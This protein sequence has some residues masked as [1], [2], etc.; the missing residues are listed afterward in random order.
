MGRRM[1]RCRRRNEGWTGG[2]SERSQ[3]P[4]ERQAETDLGRER[5]RQTDRDKPT[6]RAE[7]QRENDGKGEKLL[8]AAHE[9]WEAGTSGL[10]QVS[11]PS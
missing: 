5:Q 8:K 11:S 4:R 3:S 2:S 7:I 10:G 6:E 9:R 1:E